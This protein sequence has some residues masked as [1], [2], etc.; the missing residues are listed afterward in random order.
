M[1]FTGTTIM[2]GLIGMALA[3]AAVI[4]GFRLYMASNA[5]KLVESK[6]GTSA[7][8][9]K[10]K[11]A[12][13]FGWNRSFWLSGMVCSVALTV[14]AFNWTQYEKKISDDLLVMEKFDETEV[15]VPRTAP[16]PPPPPPPPVIEEV[17]DEDI[18]DDI[19]FEDQSFDEDEMLDADTFEDE[20]DDEE[21]APPVEDDE[22]DDEEFD[23]IFTIVEEM[24]SFPGCE[25]LPSKEERK[26]CTEK[27]LLK[28]MYQNIKYPTIARENGIEG[29]VVLQ[30]VIGKDGTVSETKVL[31]GI[32]GGCDEEAIRVVETMNNMPQKWK[33]G[34]QRGRPVQVRYNLPIRFKLAQN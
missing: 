34:E 28:Y 20:G 8:V 26:A 21:E 27:N 18:D 14:L 32:G 12:D 22:D 16:P 2:I 5:S 6:A 15:E 17:P 11:S 4:I 10:H 31:R 3:V 29:L 30:F 7:K 13:I 9:K 1:A 24:P 23:Q 25:D 19:T 33:P